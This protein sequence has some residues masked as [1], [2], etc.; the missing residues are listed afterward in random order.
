MK[1]QNSVNRPARQKHG[2]TRSALVQQTLACKLQAG[3]ADCDAGGHIMPRYAD[4]GLALQILY[5]C[6]FG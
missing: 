5:C 2:E 6:S 1:K 3:I 4:V